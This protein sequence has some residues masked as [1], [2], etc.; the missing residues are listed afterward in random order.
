MGYAIAFGEGNDF[1][2]SEGWF[3]GDGAFQYGVQAVW[4]AVQH[5]LPVTFVVLRNG[6]YGAL[7]CAWMLARVAS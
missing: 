6:I 7:A 1:F 4:T 2:G 5:Q 3:L